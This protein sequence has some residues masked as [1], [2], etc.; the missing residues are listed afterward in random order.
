V[1]KDVSGSD[2]SANFNRS[3]KAYR[4]YLQPGR[5]A[6]LSRGKSVKFGGA[7][8]WYGVSLGAKTGYDSNHKQKITAGGKPGKH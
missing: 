5:H 4:H 1:G 7:V 2:G 3:N 8:S 6:Q